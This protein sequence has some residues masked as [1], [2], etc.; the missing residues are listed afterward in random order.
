M[1]ESLYENTEPL[2][3]LEY[4]INE[5][6]R[7]DP[8]GRFYL[9]SIRDIIIQAFRGD[10]EPSI[11]PRVYLEHEKLLDFIDDTQL[12]VRWRGFLDG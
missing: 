4:E 12:S 7:E 8:E 5:I 11:E 6:G 3:V 2:N 1:Y 9:L 10:P